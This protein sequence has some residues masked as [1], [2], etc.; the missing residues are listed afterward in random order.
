MKEKRWLW[1]AVAALAGYFALL[2]LL[3]LAESGHPNAS[4]QSFSDALWYS[5]VTLST[6]GY[7]DLYPVTA[8]G[9]LIGLL[10]VLLSVY[11]PQ[12]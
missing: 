9:K 10:F 8:V 1:L 12:T 5:I 6:V 3:A 4:I 11:L 7:G 2:I